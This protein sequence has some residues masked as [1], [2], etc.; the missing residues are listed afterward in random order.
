MTYLRRV[1][2]RLDGR[3]GDEDLATLD[4]LL[5]DGGPDSILERGDLRVTGS[6]RGWLVRKG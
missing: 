2:P 4:L 3:L 5:A 1:R 6:R